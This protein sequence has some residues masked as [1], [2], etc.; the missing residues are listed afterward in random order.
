[1]INC[2][3]CRYNKTAKE[4]GGGTS[5]RL[6]NLPLPVGV[7]RSSCRILDERKQGCVFGRKKGPL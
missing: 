6:C 5:M 7:V 4:L 1:M 3:D 2:I